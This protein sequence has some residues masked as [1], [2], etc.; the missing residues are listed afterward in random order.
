MRTLKKSKYSFFVRKEN[1]SFIVYSSLSGAVILFHEE[2]YINML[3]DI[4]NKDLIEYLVKQY[5]YNAVS[6]VL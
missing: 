4:L 2:R 3:N 5:L 6:P 1:G